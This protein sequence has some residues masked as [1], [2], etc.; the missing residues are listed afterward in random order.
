MSAESFDYRIVTDGNPAVVAN[1]V[2]ELLSQG[3]QLVGTLVVTMLPGKDAHYH[4][5][6]Y[7]QALLR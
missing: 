3:W 6:M 1:R 2:S 5:L 4:A 7:T